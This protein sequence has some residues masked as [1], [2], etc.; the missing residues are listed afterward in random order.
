MT[1]KLSILIITI[2]SRAEKL[3]RLLDVLR[4][5]LPTDQSVEVII[6][7]ELPAND[8]GPTVGANR[9]A[10]MADATGDYVCFIDDD[11]MVPGNYV[12]NILGAIGKEAGNPNDLPEGSNGHYT[13]DII[14]FAERNDVVGIR[15]HYILGHNK[16]ELFI[17]SLDYNE[18]KT[19][20]GVHK[21]C[22][23]HLNPVKREI[24]LQVPFPEKNYREDMEY[25]MALLP[26]LKT[27]V[28]VEGIMYFY[29]K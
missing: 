15:G 29:L 23:N 9:N 26:L 20:D 12:D 1:P 4:P 22:P 10:A 14:N 11:D 16:P 2:P 18:W 19:V 3:Q 24:A 8:G 6:K 25:S 17:H 13:G 21:R 5:Q 27:Q 28:M 7:E